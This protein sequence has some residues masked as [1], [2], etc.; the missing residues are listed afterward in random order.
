MKHSTN[1]FTFIE[2][3]IYTGLL[4]VIM[5]TLTTFATRVIR[6]NAHTQLTSQVLDNARGAMEA[7]TREI[8]QS[9]GV[10]A[11]T[12]TFDTFPGQLS[13]STTQSLPA[14]E[15]VTY[16]DFYIDDERLYRKREGTPAELVTSEQVRVT[17]LT[18]DLLNESSATPAIQI[19]LTV[20]PAVSSDEAAAQSAV[21]FVTTAALR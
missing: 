20:E 5:F 6:Q 11:P 2:I 17:N 9:T 15:E 8:R 7:I 3:L 21:T 14:D 12:S 10:Y 4:A 19:T 18:F 13:L 1:G 16:V